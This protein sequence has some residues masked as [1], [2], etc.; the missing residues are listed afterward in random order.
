MRHPGLPLGSQQSW[1]SFATGVRTYLPSTRAYLL[2]CKNFLNTFCDLEISEAS[3][4]NDI[5]CLMCSGKKKPWSVND[6]KL[7]R[8]LQVFCNTFND[9]NGSFFTVGFTLALVIL[10]IVYIYIA[11][12]FTNL[13][14]LVFLVFPALAIFNVTL[15][16]AFLPQHSKVRILSARLLRSMKR[17]CKMMKGNMA[18]N[19]HCANLLDLKEEIV[20]KKI[21]AAFA[22]LGIRVWSFGVYTLGT[23]EMLIE[24]MCNNIIL[25]MSL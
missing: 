21:M 1:L 11:L 19:I 6:V 10:P 15:I 7:Y 25:L 5:T 3:S 2:C 22:P 9:F 18:E 13:H 8:S 23:T 14:F 4:I 12:T 24:Q 17:A 20:R 16:V